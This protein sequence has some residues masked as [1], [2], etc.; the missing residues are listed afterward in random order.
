[1]HN[2]SVWTHSLSHF[3]GIGV[4]L[5]LKP[6]FAWSFVVESLL[7]EDLCD[8][9]V[10]FVLLNILNILIGLGTRRLVRILWVRQSVQLAVLASSILHQ[11]LAAARSDGTA[12]NVDLLA[13]VVYFI[14]IHAIL[15]LVIAFNSH[16]L[17]VCSLRDSDSICRVLDLVLDLLAVL[18]LVDELSRAIGVYQS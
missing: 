7:L 3:I 11:L 6:K 14:D 13:T 12:D 4:V 9:Q 1:M 15:V 17:L 2:H 10:V 8:G 5:V 18:L 16:D